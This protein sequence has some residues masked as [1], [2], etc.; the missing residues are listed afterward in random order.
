MLE[1][2]A[3]YWAFTS[4]TTLLESADSFPENKSNLYII[5]LKSTNPSINYSGTAPLPEVTLVAE[6]TFTQKV[7]KL[8]ITVICEFA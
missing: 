5:L 3:S 2:M 7:N 4:C 8:V 1:V 6:F